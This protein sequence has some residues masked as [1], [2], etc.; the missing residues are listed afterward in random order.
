MASVLLSLESLIRMSS[1][2][3]VFLVNFVVIQFGE[4][5]SEQER[6]STATELRVKTFQVKLSQESRAK[7]SMFDVMLNMRQQKSKLQKCL[8]LYTFLSWHLTCVIENSD[9][10]QLCRGKSFRPIAMSFESRSNL[11]VLASNGDI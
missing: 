5:E 7:S 4:N 6:R 3:L 1:N 8:V 11:V 10:V 9:L 2:Q